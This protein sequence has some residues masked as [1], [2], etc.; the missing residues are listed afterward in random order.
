M[1][2]TV[3]VDMMI[4]CKKFS[5]SLNRFFKRH[6]EVDECWRETL[7]WMHETGTDFF[8]DNLL[9]DGTKNNEWRYA[10]HLDEYEDAFYIAVIER[11]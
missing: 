7:E 4:N 2:R 6:P 1:T 11:A 10:L 9:A 8:S 5:T 3:N